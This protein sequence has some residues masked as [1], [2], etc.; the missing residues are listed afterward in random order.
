M[1]NRKGV[2]ALLGIIITIIVLIPVVI[3]VAYIFIYGVHSVKAVAQSLSAYVEQVSLAIKSGSSLVVA[4]A[5][6]SLSNDQFMAQFYGNSTCISYLDQLSRI[7]VLSL[8]QNPNSLAGEYFLCSGSYNPS[9]IKQDSVW[10]YLP[11]TPGGASFPYWFTNV[12]QLNS[13]SSDLAAGINGSAG[14]L[15]YYE[16][17]ADIATT[18]G[19]SCDEFFNAV[20]AYGTATPSA[21]ITSLQCVPIASGNSTYFISVS[22]PSCAGT[23]NGC[24]SN[25]MAFLYGNPGQISYQSCVY[26]GGASIVC[27][28]SIG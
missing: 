9:A 13:P 26:H 19:Q 2:T 25:P 18:L 24:Y 7:T 6:P 22:G 17:P 21:Y 23:T 5:S 15:S 1:V 11:S 16:N 10:N 3:I 12:A 4:P 27:S 8:P 14:T 28:F 20:T